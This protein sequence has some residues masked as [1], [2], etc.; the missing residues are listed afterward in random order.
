[1]DINEHKVTED[2]ESDSEFAS[3]D[4]SANAGG[5]GLGRE[6]PPSE[7]R[8]KPKKETDDKSAPISAEPRLADDMETAE[9]KMKNL[10]VKKEEIIV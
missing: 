6:A 4:T 8:V 7:A 9:N 5:E 10:T 3:A 2:L 1:M